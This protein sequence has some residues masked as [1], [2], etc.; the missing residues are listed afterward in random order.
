[1]YYV[2]ASGGYNVVPAPVNIVVVEMPEEKVAVEI[3]E[4]TYFYFGGTFYETVS[5]GFKVVLAP[6][7]AVVSDIPEGGEEVE[8]QEVKYV[9]YNETYFQ[10]LT[11][12]GKD[13]YQVVA[14][15]SAE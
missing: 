7:G 3:G 2:E 10:P 6:D 8:I 1:V 4:I 15:E 5:D 9:L 13:V 11:Q 14:M 12:D